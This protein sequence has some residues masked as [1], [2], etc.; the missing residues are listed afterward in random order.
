MSGRKHQPFLPTEP[1]FWRYVAKSDGCWEWT[2][3]VNSKGYGRINHQGK[4][5]L[6][7]RYSWDLHNGPIPVGLYVLHHCD[8]RRCVR[9]DH[10]FLGDAGDNARDMAQK[11]RVVSMTLTADDVWAIRRLHQPRLRRELA[12]LFDTNPSHI[13]HLVL[14]RSWKHVA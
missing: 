2:R 3:G 11:E 14:R 13:S 7:H 10:L 1:R 4:N 12:V 8:N 6:T 5:M 9:P